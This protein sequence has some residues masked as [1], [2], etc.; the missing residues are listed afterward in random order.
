MLSH[1]V[2]INDRG[3]KI[4]CIIHVIEAIAV[5]SYKLT[6]TFDLILAISQI[7]RINNYIDLEKYIRLN[8][9]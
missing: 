3:K 1:N 8:S 5:I 2:K 9:I 4:I 6:I 7:D